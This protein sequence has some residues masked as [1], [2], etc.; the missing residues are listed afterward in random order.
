MVIETYAVPKLF[1][2]LKL[3]SSSYN[4]SEPRNYQKKY[5]AKLQNRQLED[6]YN[7]RKGVGRYTQQNYRIA[8]TT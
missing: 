2:Q 7:K 6:K 5:A 1:T 8:N 4:Y 3:R